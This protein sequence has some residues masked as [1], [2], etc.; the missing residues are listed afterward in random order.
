[1][2]H[3]HDGFGRIIRL[4]PL[5]GSSVCILLGIQETGELVLFRIALLEHHRERHSEVGC[6]DTAVLLK[7]RYDGYAVKDPGGRE[8]PPSVF[9]LSFDGDDRRSDAKARYPFGHIFS[10]EIKL[11]GW[12]KFIQ[13]G[14][15]LG[16]RIG[17]VRERKIA[18]WARN[19]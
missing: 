12:S 8:V 15:P 16:P 1:M 14:I 11:V 9:R 5:N 3:Q 18:G 10:A 4:E 19:R 13:R 17:F 6:Q 2:N 7:M